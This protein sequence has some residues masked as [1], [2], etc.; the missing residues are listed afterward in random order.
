MNVFKLFIHL[1][2]F[3]NRHQIRYY[4]IVIGTSVKCI[5]HSHTYSDLLRKCR[6]KNLYIYSNKNL[7]PG[8]FG[9]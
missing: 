4:Q 6:L 3:N 8:H 5:F 1:N 7:L 9:S 2:T